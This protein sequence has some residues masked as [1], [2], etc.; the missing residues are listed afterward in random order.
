MKLN[1]FWQL[2]TSYERTTWIRVL[3][4]RRDEGLH[5]GGSFSSSVSKSSLRERFKAFDAAFEKL[6]P[7]YRSF[8]GRFR[9]HRE[10]RDTQ[11][12]ILSTQLM[13]LR[14]LWLIF[15]K[16]AHILCLARQVPLK[17]SSAGVLQS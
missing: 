8:L 17:L 1:E 13:I 7:S 3:Y 11:R 12:F 9:H 2:A 16:G 15:L 14:Y 4:C 10:T 6:L 5:V